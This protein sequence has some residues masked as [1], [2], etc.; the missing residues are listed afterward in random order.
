MDAPKPTEPGAPSRQT[1][2]E[3]F[4]YRVS[5]DL[6]SPISSI[7]GFSELLASDCGSK[8]DAQGQRYLEAVKFAAQRL[9]GMIEGL[10]AL[11]RV[12]RAA[13]AARTCDMTAVTGVARNQA[14][15]RT[16]R[17]DAVWKMP[18][19][20][21]Q[22]LGVESELRTLFGHLFANALQ[23]NPNPQPLVELTCREEPGR[24]VFSVRDNGPGIEPRSHQEIFN[25]FMRLVPQGQDQSVGMGLALA[26]KIVELHGGQ[27][28]VESSKGQGATFSVALPRK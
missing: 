24:F 8:L 15:A 19:A 12:G 6:R 4:I 14:V 13:D 10:L 21:P 2:L 7:L 9:N 11:S 16:G 17:K 1:D 27:I 23:Y 22:I 3:Q 25:I 5:H 28:W 18:A 20:L 26:K